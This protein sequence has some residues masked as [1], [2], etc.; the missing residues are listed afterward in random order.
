[1]ILSFLL[2]IYDEDGGYNLDAQRRNFY[3]KNFKGLYFG[4]K[5]EFLDIVN[6]INSNWSFRI[7]YY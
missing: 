6:M 1:M 4:R 5:S 3:Y 2:V 7:N